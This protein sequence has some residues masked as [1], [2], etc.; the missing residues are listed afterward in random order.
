MFLLPKL[1]WQRSRECFAISN[2]RLFA[3]TSRDCCSNGGSAVSQLSYSRC[4]ESNLTWTLRPK[5]GSFNTPE[6]GKKSRGE[7][8]DK[9]RGRKV[10][11]SWCGTTAWQ[12]S[13]SIRRERIRESLGQNRPSSPAD[14]DRLPGRPVRVRRPRSPYGYA[15][16]VA[17]G[18]RQQ[19]LSC[20]CHASRRPASGRWSQ[21]IVSR[22]LRSDYGTATVRAQDS[23]CCSF[24]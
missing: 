10:I 5:S 17:S 20:R 24:C 12:S 15:S 21:P 3:E 2:F 8:R 13:C 19:M 9:T 6:A 14:S 23:R 22:G 4:F 18:G 11:T 1:N 7:S 16:G